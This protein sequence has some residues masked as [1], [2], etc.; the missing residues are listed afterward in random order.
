MRCN[1]HRSF[2]VF[3]QRDLQNS[4][5]DGAVF[6]A[7]ATHLANKPFTSTNSGLTLGG[8]YQPLRKHL[9]FKNMNMKFY[10]YPQ[11]T[12]AFER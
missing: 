11:F 9:H 4:F 6:K 12:E 2:F 8:I 7:F 1:Q 5:A 10:F 3:F